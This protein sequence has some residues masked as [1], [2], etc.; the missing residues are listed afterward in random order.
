M[1]CKLT[2]KSFSVIKLAEISKLHIYRYG[3]HIAVSAH[4]IDFLRNKFIYRNLK[5]LK[6]VII[7]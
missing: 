7:V 6:S 4:C 3:L 5:C 1:Q 2:Q